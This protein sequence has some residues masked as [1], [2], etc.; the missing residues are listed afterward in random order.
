MKD[1]LYYRLSF[2]VPFGP[3]SGNGGLAIGLAA[4]DINRVGLSS[5]AIRLEL[6]APQVWHR[7][8]MAHSP[9]LRTQTPI[10]S[11][12]PPQSEARSPGR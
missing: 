9:F 10:G 11:M 2:E 7:W 8:M 12:I 3:Q 1:M 4:I 6:S 5:A